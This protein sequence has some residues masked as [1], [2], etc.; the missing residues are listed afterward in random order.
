MEF[1]FVSSSSKIAAFDLDHTLIKPLGNRT[2]PRDK[3]DAQYAF[4]GDI[5]PKKLDQLHRDG[6]AIVIFTNQRRLKDPRIIYDKVAKYVGRDANVF[7]SKEYDGYR[8]P[9]PRMF[10]KFLELNSSNIEDLFYVG[11]AAGRHSPSEQ[12]DFSDS[13]LKFALNIRARFY[14]P[15]EFFL[16]QRQQYE[17]PDIPVKFSASRSIGFFPEMLPI[18]ILHIGMPGCGKSWLSRHIARDAGLGKSAIVSN[19]ETGASLKT[20]RLAEEHFKN[21]TQVVIVDNTHASRKSRKPFVDLGR[22]YK[23]LIVFIRHEMP[24]ESCR[25]LN[26]HRAYENNCRYVPDVAYRMFKKHLEEPN[27]DEY[28]RLISYVPKLDSSKF[29]LYF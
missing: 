19:D 14:T 11:D 4:D 1:Q 21:G 8:K 23:C 12:K 9:S 25:Y 27:S 28:D 3:N 26:R 6:Y 16:G 24:E 15:E 29:N 17:A 20:R 7:I 22:K 10:E 5:I 13:D 18:L 2:F